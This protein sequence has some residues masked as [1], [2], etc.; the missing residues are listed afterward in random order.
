MGVTKAKADRLAVFEKEFMLMEKD[1]FDYFF[2]FPT[3]SNTT[4]RDANGQPLDLHTRL[5]RRGLT[6]DM[7]E[8]EQDYTGW[9]ARMREN[10]R[11]VELK[12]ASQSASSSTAPEKARQEEVTGPSLFTQKEIKSHSSEKNSDSDSE[13]DSPAPR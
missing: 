1:A 10:Y 6:H 11:G 4:S 8:S 7:F 13:P 9:R 2:N 12:N 5:K 3:D